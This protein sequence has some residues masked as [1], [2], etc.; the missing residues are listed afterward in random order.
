VKHA[1]G[2]KPTREV[3]IVRPPHRGFVA[4]HVEIHEVIR[5]APADIHDHHAPVDLRPG[6]VED[7]AAVF[8]LVEAVE[9]QAVD[10]RGGL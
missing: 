7:N 4:A 2:W 1:V 6:P 9:D 10:E 3:R 8:V 5:L